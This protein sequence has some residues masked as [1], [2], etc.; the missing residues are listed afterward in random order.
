[1]SWIIRVVFS[2][3]NEYSR[4]FGGSEFAARAQAQHTANMPHVSYVQIARV[5]DTIVSQS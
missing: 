3:G 4:T 2:D 1:M 5:I